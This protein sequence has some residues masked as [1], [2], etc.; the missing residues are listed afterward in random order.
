MKSATNHVTVIVGT[1]RTGKSTE[2]VGLHND[3]T[4]SPSA[5]VCFMSS[6]KPGPEDLAT[7]TLLVFY[8]PGSCPVKSFMDIHEDQPVKF[9]HLFIDDV[10]DQHMD[11]VFHL[12]KRFSELNI[13]VVQ[14]T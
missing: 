8:P 13:T 11:N 6:E 9:T 3:A 5:H 2:L 10:A 4:E 1:R 12:A 14:K 7:R